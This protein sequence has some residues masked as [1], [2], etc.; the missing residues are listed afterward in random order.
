VN[1][2][3]DWTRW[4]DDYDDANSELSRR[5]RVVQHRIRGWLEADAGVD[6]QVVSICAGQGRDIVPVAA[7]AGPGSLRLTLVETDASN[8]E[9]ALESARR[10]GIDVDVRRDD[11]GVA[12]TY[13]DLPRADLLLACGIF[14][15]IA[16]ADVFRTVDA[17]PQLC[18][19]AATVIW[20]RSRRAPDL[21]G[22]IRARLARAGFAERAFDAPDD[23][24]FSVG[25]CQLV[26]PPVPLVDDSTWFT[27]LR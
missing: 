7:E 4:H 15:N 8:A 18:N 10:L 11:A 12:R 5:L 22:D 9:R 13:A 17:L 2:Q 27:F 20:T 26:V 24:L 6:R 25:T 3:T 14:G 19:H 16:D 21:T 23:A 1:G